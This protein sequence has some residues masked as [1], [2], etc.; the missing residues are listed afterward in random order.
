M[1]NKFTLATLFLVYFIFAILLNSTGTVILQVI[2][3][4]DIGKAEASILE[5]MKDIS[6][7]VVTF[8]A[9]SLLP[10]LGYKKALIISMMI[11][12]VG[13]SLMPLMPSFWTT[14]LLFLLLGVSFALAKISVYSSV[15]L[16]TNSKHAHTSILNLLEGFFMIGV[17]S[18]SWLFASFIDSLH[19]QSAS[20]LNAYWILAAMAIGIALLL[21]YAKL[22]DA[23][24]Y[25]NQQDSYAKN[26]GG[27]LRLLLRPLVCVYVLSAFV[28]VLIEQSI[29]TWLPTFNN[30]ILKLPLAMSVQVASIFAASCAIGRLCASVVTRKIS[31]YPVVNICILSVALLIVM[32]LPLTSHIS[33]NP[34]VT[35]FNAPVAAYIF[36]MLG[37]FLAPIYP[38]INSVML[39]SLPKYQHAAMTGLLV[40]FS[41]LGGTTGSLVTGY[42]FGKFNGQ[43]AFYLTLAPILMI[44]FSLYFFKRSVDKVESML[45]PED[46][47]EEKK[48]VLASP[49]LGITKL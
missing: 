23:S 30:E 26:L 31:W 45:N 39:T 9:A 19:P 20:W 46:T 33:V 27:M 37:F 32:T 16:L 1:N 28:F 36:P 42:I 14:K 11:V 29:G 40:I 18:G 2:N 24:L 15:G 7:A 25:T 6:I 12:A 34:N 41:A 35:W 38:C 47:A 49:S 4:Y 3:T 44:L 43:T 13:C 10:R 8:F 48:E 22:N 21:S 17:L 5:A